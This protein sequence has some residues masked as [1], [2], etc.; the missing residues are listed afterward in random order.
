LKNLRIL[1]VYGQVAPLKWQDP[2]E[3]VD[4][5]P[6]ITES[7]LQTAAKNIKTIYEEK[8]SAELTEAHELLQRAERI[9]FLGFGYAPENMDVLKLPESIPLGC[10]VY[11]T[12]FNM[13]PMEVEHIRHT[14]HFG[15]KRDRPNAYMSPG[16][17]IVE[18][19]D[20]LML[21]RRYL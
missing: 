3:G 13:E 21:L 6:Q 8:E 10:K 18:P 4:Y 20:C 2:N 12:A 11:G 9:F 5:R 15:R 19:C 1:H 16:Y 17:T 14:V 7:L